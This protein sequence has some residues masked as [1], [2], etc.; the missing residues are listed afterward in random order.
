MGQARHGRLCRGWRV[1]IARLALSNGLSRAH[2]R[3]ASASTPHARPCGATGHYGRAIRSGIR[4]GRDAGRGSRIR[5]GSATPRSGA[6]RHGL[7]PSSES[8]GCHGRL[9]AASSAAAQDGE[10]KF[11]RGMIVWYMVAKPMQRILI[12]SLSKNIIRWKASTAKEGT[13]PSEGN[14]DRRREN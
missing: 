7:A 10:N 6:G 11:L 8:A 1:G 2:T 3:C 14:R 12:Y 9:H 4:A 5:R 13:S